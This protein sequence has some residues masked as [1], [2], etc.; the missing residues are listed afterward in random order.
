MD[1]LARL[2]SIPEDKREDVEVMFQDWMHDPNS[3]LY[4]EGD[5]CDLCRAIK[6]DMAYTVKLDWPVEW[7]ERHINFTDKPAPEGTGPDFTWGRVQLFILQPDE[8]IRWLCTRRESYDHG[9]GI[10]V[11]QMD[12]NGM[13]QLAYD[14]HD[15]KAWEWLGGLAK[16]GAATCMAMNM[17]YDS[18]QARAYC[19]AN[20]DKK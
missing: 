7:K 5:E 16:V 12:V 19:E 2:T 15:K 6:D 1:V 14:A 8:K 17:Y 20:D 13:Q 3:L 11:V 9:P 10:H 4:A 18:D